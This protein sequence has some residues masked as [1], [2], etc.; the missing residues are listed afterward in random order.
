MYP[1]QLHILVHLQAE[2]CITVFMVETLFTAL[3]SLIECLL[4]FLKLI[5]PIPTPVAV[6][7]G[8][9]DWGLLSDAEM[10]ILG[11]PL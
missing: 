9:W 10:E 1:V 2:I 6:T 11:S 4:S 8:I 5:P 7:V 3:K